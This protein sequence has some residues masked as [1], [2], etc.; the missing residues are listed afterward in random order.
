MQSHVTATRTILEHV[1]FPGE[2]S[3]VPEWAGEHHELLNGSGYPK[4]LRGDEIPRE[5]RLLTLLDIFEALTAKDRP[6]KKPMSLERALDVMHKMVDEGSL[7][8]AML[9]L[10]KESRAWETILK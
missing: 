1:H 5:V 10:F 8:G 7:D 4:H 6:Y 2:F 9:E 3:M